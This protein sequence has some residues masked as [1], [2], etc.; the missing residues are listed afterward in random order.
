[1]EIVEEEG[2][3]IKPKR[4]R[5]GEDNNK[6]NEDRNARAKDILIK[7]NGTEDPGNGTPHK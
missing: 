1:M 2:E 6:D 3:G 5:L 4:I 7:D